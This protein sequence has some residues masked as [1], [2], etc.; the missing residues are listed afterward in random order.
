MLSTDLNRFL[1]P[2]PPPP[3]VS[4]DAV[5]AEAL[6]T[7]RPAERIDVPTWAK[8]RRVNFPG[9]S[10]KWRNDFAPYM[11]EPAGMVTS[12]KY[13]GLV[14]V[15]PS[16]TVKSESLVLNTIGHAIACQPQDMLV[17]CQTQDS[18]KQFS[19]RKLRPMIRENEEL[20][21]RQ[22][23]GR[24]GDN[25]YEKAFTGGMNLFIG[26]PVMGYFSQNE[27]RTVLLC[28]FDRYKSDDIEGEGNAFSLAMKRTQ[29]AGSLGMAIAESSP[30]RPITDDDDWEPEGIHEA[31]PCTGILAEYNNGTRACFYW[32]C[33][34][35]GDPF[36]P[37][38]ER[39]V[40]EAKGSPSDRAAT[41]EM[42]CP[43]GCCIAP[44]R[45]AELNAKGEW[46]HETANGQSAVPK[47]DTAIRESDIVSY[48][49]EGPVAAMQNWRD[50]VLRYET[51]KQDFERTGDE[52]TLKA[53][54]T[55]DQGRA[56]KP[57][58]RTIGESLSVDA[59]KALSVRSPLEIAPAGTRFI[60][61][62]VDVQGNR[63]VVQ[64]D[65][66]CEGL[67]RQLIDRFEL[68]TPPESAP[69]ADGKRSIDPGRYVE[70]W[71][72]LFDLLDRSYPVAESG[73]SLLPRGM[74][75]DLRGAPGVTANAYK[76]LRK[77]K[78]KGQGHRVFLANNQSGL[79][80]DRAFYTEPEKRNGQKIKGRAPYKLVRIRTDMLKDEIAL[81]LTRKDDGPGTYRLPDALPDSVFGEFCAEHRTEKGW[82]RIKAGSRN[83]ALDLAVY[84]KGLA[85]I[86]GAEKIDWQRPP[87]W[88]APVKENNYSVQIVGDDQ[89]DPVEAPVKS[90]RRRRR[91]ISKGI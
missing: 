79:Q 73:F 26:W 38:V 66:F 49:C 14:F 85:I 41:V 72:V 36:T 46:L 1:P 88:A 34:S 30:G 31:P 43:N 74:I 50:L 48:R 10:G 59:L 68:I 80:G 84:G 54:V 18:A 77:S 71:D 29:Q 75:V 19:T 39:L 51:A 11:T 52:T 35:C 2:M 69:N 76:F 13:R 81:A 56:Y 61:F 91:V 44:D 6:P 21:S 87:Q 47:D 15:G 67:A 45:K 20:S 90:T 82:E 78:R 86:L 22:F 57:A 9:Y 70:D 17:V 63:F 32:I 89:P 24:G 62:S 40:Y 3:F 55:L 16:R 25:L 53:T 64:A 37:L 65:A 12:R 60:L 5:V 58:V 4:P 7:L 27:Y 8:R 28:D 83:E 42:V 33:P 23:S